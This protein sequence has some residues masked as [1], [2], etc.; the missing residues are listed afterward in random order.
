MAKQDVGDLETI[1]INLQSWLGEQLG[2]EAFELGELNFPEASGESSVTLL[3]DTQ[4]L[5]NGRHEHEKFVLRMVP[6]TSEVFESHDLKLQ[7]DVMKVMAKEGV[8]VPGLVAYE[9]N[10]DLLGS[11]FYVMRFVDGQIPPDQPPM[12]F[13][14]WV[15]DLSTEER[16]AMWQSG[17]DV[18]AQ[19]HR[20]D[21]SAYDLP[22][23]PQAASDEPPAML[24]MRKYLRLLELGVRDSADPNINIATKLLQDTM[25]QDGPRTLCWGDS[26]PGNIIYQNLKPAA[27]VDWELANIGDPLTDLAWYYWI[28]HCNSVGL[29]TEKMSGIPDY[30]DGYKYW[31]SLTGLPIDNIAWYELFVLWRFAIIMEKKMMAMTLVD[32][33]FADFPNHASTQ[34]EAAMARL[35]S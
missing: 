29:G 7:F 3:F 14:S 6:K 28:D 1:R 16:A 31:Q 4:W 10:P 24:E 17:L 2:R 20:V 27:V 18:L 9:A 19:I 23:L 13:G 21:I 8:P 32:A 34:L 15:L 25:P 26:R 11:D 33:N 30:M 35:R 5:E 12:A 22:S